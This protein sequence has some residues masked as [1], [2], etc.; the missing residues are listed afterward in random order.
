M[1]ILNRIGGALGT[2]TAAEMESASVIG[3]FA[4]FPGRGGDH[5]SGI[6]SRY[7]RRR[8][9]IRKRAA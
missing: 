7:S 2:A 5:G 3:M 9:R 4:E 1:N 6:F 8:A